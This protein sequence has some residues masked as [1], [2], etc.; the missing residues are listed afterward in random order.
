MKHFKKSIEIKCSVERAFDFHKDTNNLKLITPPGISVKILSIELPLKLGSEIVLNVTQFGLIRNKWHIKLTEFV[1]N[2]LI[3]DTQIKGP[4][5]V[6][7]HKH[8][9]EDNGETTLMTDELEFELPFGILGDIAYSVFVA[10][11][12][13]NQ[14]EY[15]QKVTKKILESRSQ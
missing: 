9:F 12:I 3:T 10:R 13:R 6:W 7:K 11:L 1:E 4:F 2:K 8:I 14:F 15:R 5:A